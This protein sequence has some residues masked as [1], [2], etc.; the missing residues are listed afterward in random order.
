MTV[1]RAT[2]TTGSDQRKI[3]TERFECTPPSTNQT[4]FNFMGFSEI[5]A[6]YRV[7]TPGEI[8]DPSR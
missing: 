1:A 4:F 5:F 6:K 3:Y 7:G 8:L 2:L